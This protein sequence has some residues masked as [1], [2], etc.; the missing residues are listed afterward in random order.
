MKLAYYLWMALERFGANAISFLGN[1]CLSYFVVPSQYG[2]VAALAIFTNLIYVLVDCG[3]SDGLVRYKNATDKDFNTMFWFNTLTGVTLCLI[4][5]IIAPYVA[6][7]LDEPETENVLR[8]FG[9]GAILSALSISQATRM[10]YELRFKTMSLINLAATASMAS[11]AILMGVAGLGYWA[12]AMLTFG[13]SFFLL[14]YLVV[15][16][17]WHLR[18]EFSMSTFKDLWKF[19]ANLMLTVITTQIAQ[20]IYSLILGKISV[21]KAG[22]F[23]QAQKLENTPLK[24]L[25]STI[26][27]TSYVMIAKEADENSKNREILKVYSILV[28]LLASA[29]GLAF[30]LSGQLID[31]IFP[32]K[33]LPV[34]PYFRLMLILGFFQAMSRFQQ[35][36]YKIY[37][38]TGIIRNIVFIEN[39]ALVLMVLTLFYVSV[40]VFEI[41]LAAI[42][43]TAVMNVVSL[44]VGVKIAKTTFGQ[45][46]GRLLGSLTIAG[47]SAAVTF[48]AASLIG[49]TIVAVSAGIVLYVTLSVILCRVV[50][51]SSYVAIKAWLLSKFKNR[52]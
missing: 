20:N 32:D 43:L 40:D 10:R 50:M 29:V 23:V 25:E 35:N 52:N 46:I 5:N 45:F 48:Y 2:I 16:T 19:G 34:I 47:V 13:Y 31:L 8:L 41:I 6:S 24:S 15:F 12:V 17:K 18:V 22:Y 7:Y 27:Y 28:L 42:A 11:V 26:T 21:A 30:S 36:F 39:V 38:K 4:F 3:L 37:G 51:R 44:Y 33:W 1:I 14:F 49:S 9:F